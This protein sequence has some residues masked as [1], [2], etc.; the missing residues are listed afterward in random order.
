MSL[1]NNPLIFRSNLKQYNNA[2]LGS[3]RESQYL[4]AASIAS[5]KYKTP[6]GREEASRKI[7]QAIKIKKIFGSNRDDADL[8]YELG[9]AKPD[10]AAFQYF[11]TY[12][13]IMIIL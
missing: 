7:K 4:G 3:L 5:E 2:E 9:Q 1:E 12:I 11:N 6:Y 13:H 10:K 8:W